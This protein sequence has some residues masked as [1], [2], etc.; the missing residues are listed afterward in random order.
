MVISFVLVAVEIPGLE[1]RTT[2]TIHP[3]PSTPLPGEYG[4]KTKNTENINDAFAGLSREAN[5]SSSITSCSITG[6]P[7]ESGLFVE[8]VEDPQ[9]RRG[10][11]RQARAVCSRQSERIRK[12]LTK[13]VRFR[14]AGFD[15]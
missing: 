13:D 3:Y 9:G 4:N 2:L 7:P 15:R 11:V 8:I 5:G 14:E 12:V 10:F 6:A 1:P